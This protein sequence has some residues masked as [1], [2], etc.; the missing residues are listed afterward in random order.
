M[1][2]FRKADFPIIAD[3]IIEEKERRK[4][5]RKDREKIW[6]EIDRQIAMTP[7]TSHKKMISNG[8]LVDDEDKA[9]MPECELP[10]QAQTLEVL[11]ADARRM[12]FP[13]AG[14]WFQSHA[15]LTDEYL[16]RVDFQALISG[17]V[18]E[19]PTQI[20]QDAAD[21]LVYGVVSHFHRQYDFFGNVDLINAES[22]KYGMGVGRARIVNKEVIINK[23]TGAVSQKQKIP[24]LFP[25]SIKSTYLDDRCY[26]V[27]NE[28]HIIGPAHIFCG[29]K[30]IEDLRI[31]AKNG[32]SD[33]E[34]ENGGWM[35]AALNDIEGKKG[36]VE[37]IEYEGDLVVPRK[38]AG[39]IYIPGAIVSVVLD[40][41]ERQ[42]YRFRLRKYDFSSYIEFPYHQE[43]IE[44]PYATSPLMKGW[45]IQKAAVDAMNRLL[46]VA[47]LNGGPPLSWDSDNPT[48]AARGG[49][50]I[51]P[52]AK[53]KSTG[54]GSV[55]VH[56]IGDPVALWQLYTG[57][58]MQYSDVVG[59]NAPRLGAQTVSHTTAFAKD[60]EI[61][62][63]VARTVNYVRNTLKGPLTKW[64]DMAYQMGRDV[65][66]DST[67][68]IE[69]YNGFVDINKDYLPDIVV[70]D[71]HGSGGPQEEAIKNQNK[72]GSL[73]M[74]LSMEQ[75]AI[76]SGMPPS[77]NIQRAQDEVLRNG[78]W[79]DTSVFFST[80][81]PSEATPVQPDMAGNPQGLGTGVTAALQTLGQ[82][83]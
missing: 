68:F 48:L 42:V 6:S 34:D 79:T 73:Q 65:I 72:L 17:D 39:N 43:H 7:D 16:G 71:V 11:K 57:F 47:A 56:Q 69:A 22:F 50:V 10:L 77:I 8:G 38:T 44:D 52:Y 29:H 76:A 49:P 27:M 54:K 9:W 82:S 75:L 30:H 46:I 66:K 60:Q 1:G 62:R 28:G 26:S 13:D 51:K 21:K 5:D 2:K 35:P 59:V 78:G 81:G 53:W 61:T 25:R 14:P 32:S 55:E 24:V 33:P 19:V 18:N 83:V 64:V 3:Y 63:G 36:L 12:L 70:F 4:R 41:K 20:D 23:A 80:N 15:A 58:L 40:G 67:I 74:A 31:A 37:V 45:P